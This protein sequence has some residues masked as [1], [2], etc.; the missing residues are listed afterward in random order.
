MIAAGK[1]INLRLPIYDLRL[2]D[3]QDCFPR[4]SEVMKKEVD[5]DEKTFKDRTKK[6]AVAY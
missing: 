5:M 3:G 2:A 4:S 6:L 1:T